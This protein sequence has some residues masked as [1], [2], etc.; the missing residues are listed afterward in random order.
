[1]DLGDRLVDL[2]LQHARLVGQHDLVPAQLEEIR[3]TGARLVVV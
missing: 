1:V 2:V 3:T